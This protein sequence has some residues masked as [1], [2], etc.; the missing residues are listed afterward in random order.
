MM[1]VLTMMIIGNNLWMKTKVGNIGNQKIL[2][3]L[4]KKYHKRKNKLIGLY[5]KVKINIIIIFIQTKLFLII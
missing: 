4:N 3:R 1:F 5:T 2:N